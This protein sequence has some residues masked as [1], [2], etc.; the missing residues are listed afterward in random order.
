MDVK[1]LDLHTLRTLLKFYK[2]EMS[3][4][5]KNGRNKIEQS[6]LKAVIMDIKE[7]INWVYEKALVDTR[8]DNVSS[9]RNYY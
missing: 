4:A 7:S 8:A 1:A 9:M 3:V 5:M 2:Q 6:K